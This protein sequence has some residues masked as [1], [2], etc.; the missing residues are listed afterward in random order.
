MNKLAAIILSIGLVFSPLANSGVKSKAVK[1]AVATASVKVFKSHTIKQS[2]KL[3]LQNAAKNKLV[4]NELKVGKYKDVLLSRTT[5]PVKGKRGLIENPNAHHIP[6]NKYMNQ[7]GV[8]KNNGIAIEMQEARHKLTRT[9][10]NGNKEII[11]A[12]ET[13]RQ[14]LG[15]DVRDVKKIYEKSGHYSKDTRKSLQEVIKQNKANNPGL[16]DKVK[17]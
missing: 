14:A 16:F 15:K 6:S 9:Y 4:Q 1:G 8:D 10:K 5:T 3:A 17:K 13:P 2:K 12:N 11:K 7:K